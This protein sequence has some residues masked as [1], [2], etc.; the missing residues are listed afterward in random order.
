MVLTSWGVRF[1]ALVDDHELVRDAAAA[2][3]GQRLQHDL[4]ALDQ[5]ADALLDA[6][7]RGVLAWLSSLVRRL[8]S[9]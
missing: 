9:R 5:A 4:P 7:Q 3:V 1:W 6:G 8:V 2:N